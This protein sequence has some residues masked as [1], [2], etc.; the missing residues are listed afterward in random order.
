MQ[1]RASVQGSSLR[2]SCQLISAPARLCALCAQAAHDRH[3]TSLVGLDS[4]HAAH[5]V[6]GTHKNELASLHTVT[7]RLVT[8]P[9]DPPVS[10]ALLCV[11]AAHDRHPASRVGLDSHHAAH[12]VPGTHED[13]PASPMRSD[14]AAALPSP[15]DTAAIA[16]SPP[17]T[18]PSEPCKQ[19]LSKL[20]TAND[21]V[22]S[23][24]TGH[25]LPVR[26]DAAAALLSPCHTA[27]IAPH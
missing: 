17:A 10:S 15:G 2:E 3:P 27:A 18:P 5:V 9:S 11:Q 6:P 24:Q 13:P 16:T 12:V 21:P 8:D 14:A 22:T 1:V 7:Q 4:H 19:L 20:F 26:S 23:R 25:N